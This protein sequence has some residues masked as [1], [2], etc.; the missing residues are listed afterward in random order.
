MINAILKG[1]LSL[2]TS[3]LSIFLTPINNLVSTYLPDFSNAL[4]KIA[5][6]FVMCTGKIGWVLD[7][8]LID[9]ETIS[10]LV[11]VMI[12]KLTLPY[13]ISSVKS[14]VKWWRSLKL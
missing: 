7:S 14:I 1:I 5:D 9:K 3:L 10:L 11:T 2:L 13:L 8:L 4:T 12:M 6:F